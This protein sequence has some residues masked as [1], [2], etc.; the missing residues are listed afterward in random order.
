MLILPIRV[1]VARETGTNVCILSVE[2]RVGLEPVAPLGTFSLFSSR[3]FGGR[4]REIDKAERVKM[5]LYFAAD[6]LW[7]T[8]IR[9]VA[10]GLNIPVR[11]VRNLSMLQA[12]LAD[13]P[14]RGVVV[15]LDGGDAAIELITH[16]RAPGGD[17]SYRSIRIVAWGPHVEVDKLRAAKAAGADAVMVRGAFSRHLPDVLRELEAGE[18]VADEMEE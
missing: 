8:R 15:D 10:D 18:P 4:S 12:R 7:A 1:V 3:A 5:I 6:L 14:V 9:A 17:G 2:L 16:M 13:S 11:P